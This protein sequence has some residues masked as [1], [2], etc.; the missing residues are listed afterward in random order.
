M[1]KSQESPGA[2]STAGGVRK[3]AK[4][5]FTYTLFAGSEGM[6][7]LHISNTGPRCD[8]SR[9]VKETRV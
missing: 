2:I 5:E 1:K 9:R 7:Y 3:L 6:A 4:A 8:T